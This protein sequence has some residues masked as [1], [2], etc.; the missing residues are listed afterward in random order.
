MSVEQVMIA[1]QMETPKSSLGL[2][3]L[4]CGYL[5]MRTNELYREV[6]VR[7]I[8]GRE[9]DM[10]SSNQIKDAD[11]FSLL[12][13]NCVMR[14]GPITERGKI[15]QAVDDLTTGDRVFLMFAIRR[16]TLGDEF[17][18]RVKCPEC[19]K[20]T[21]FTVDLSELKTDE[22]A[23]PHKRVYDTVLP[24]GKTA[25]FRIS[26]GHDEKTRAK[27]RAKD[28]G[29]KASKAILMRLELL[30]GEA[31]TLDAVKSM[32][33]RDRAALRKEFEKVEGGIDLEQEFECPACG[34]E[35]KSDLEVDGRSFFFPS[36]TP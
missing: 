19:K 26:T 35:W 7:E 28:E 15:F 9:E 20:E 34:H 21:L 12:L 14:I 30:D 5:D 27:M 24:S 4:P 8:T 36:E 29:D 10:L 22:M 23:E 6:E 2:Y 11:K 18:V 17:P 16:V 3:E 1:N 13:A 33:L 32:P 31:P 25:R